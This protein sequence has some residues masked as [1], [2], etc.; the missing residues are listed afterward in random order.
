MPTDLFLTRSGDALTL[1]PVDAL[2]LEA[3]EG[4]AYGEV[5]RAVV[6]RGRN[7]KHHRKMIGILR[8]VYDAMP[9]RSAYPT[10]ESF[11]CAVKIALG[12]FAIHTALD[13][14]T[15]PVADSISFA[16]MPQ[17]EFAQFYDRFIDLV[18]TKI[19]P[20][21]Q[22]ETLEKQLYKIIDGV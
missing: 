17:E 15:F 13:G 5:V 16:S 10:L 14:S 12:H 11:L 9:D 8:I 21:I 20:N 3:I 2:S 1:A 22:R 6:T 4:L 19:L 18:V 7:I